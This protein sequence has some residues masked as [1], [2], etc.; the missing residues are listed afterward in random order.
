MPLAYAVPDAAAA[1]LE[2]ARRLFAWFTLGYAVT[3]CLS[4]SLSA[5]GLSQ[6]PQNSIRWANWVYPLVT[7]PMCVPLAIGAAMM[8][9]DRDR[10]ALVIRWAAAGFCAAGLASTLA[11]QFAF[12]SPGGTSNYMIGYVASVLL[13]RGVS[14]LFSLPMLLFCLSFPLRRVPR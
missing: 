8:L 1:H 14:I 9:K 6:I 10:G 4:S 13:I 2:R 12:G 3:G 7:I 11:Q 5:Y